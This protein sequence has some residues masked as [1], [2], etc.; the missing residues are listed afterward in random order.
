[1]TTY[2]TVDDSFAGLHRAGWSSGDA[3]VFSSKGLVW[4]VS[5]TNGENLIKAGGDGPGW[6]AV[7]AMVARGSR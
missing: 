5:S 2:P 4:L 6:D 3:Q 7:R 1:M